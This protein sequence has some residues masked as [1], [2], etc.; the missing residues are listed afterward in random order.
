M[1]SR[2]QTAYRELIIANAVVPESVL[3]AAAFPE[4]LSILRA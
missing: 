4:E 3:R 2:D 1:S